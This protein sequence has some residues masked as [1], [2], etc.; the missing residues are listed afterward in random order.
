MITKTMVRPFAHDSSVA[1]APSSSH[2][3]EAYNR[4]ISDFATASS[5]FPPYR[6][7]TS[8]MSQPLYEIAHMV[9]SWTKK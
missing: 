5:K 6:S 9:E 1:I 7:G 4:C 8:D 3:L 2:L